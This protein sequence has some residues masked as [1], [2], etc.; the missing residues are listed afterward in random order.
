MNTMRRT[1]E[2]TA[3]AL[4]FRV[5]RMR[6]AIERCFRMRPLAGHRTA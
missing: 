6:R 3:M 5:R 1:M 4:Y 2:E